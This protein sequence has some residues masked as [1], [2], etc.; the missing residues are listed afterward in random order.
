MTTA[1]TSRRAT[2]APASDDVARLATLFAG[3]TKAHGT[4][5]VPKKEG[6]KWRITGTAQTIL[7]PVTEALWRQH[8]AGT[9][10]LGVIPIK[11]D[12]SC[13]WGSIDYD[14]YDVD[15]LAVVQRVGRRD[16]R[17]CRA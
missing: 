10:P 8:V 16:C 4:H 3:N 13:S 11:N 6:L 15:L 1:S 5:G 17:W 12:D 7:R 9:H 14:V 2:A